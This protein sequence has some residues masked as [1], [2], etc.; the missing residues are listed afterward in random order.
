MILLVGILTLRGLIDSAG[1][2]LPRILIRPK[3]AANS[4]TPTN[5]LMFPMFRT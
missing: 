4:S 2:F 1:V 3:N 5:A